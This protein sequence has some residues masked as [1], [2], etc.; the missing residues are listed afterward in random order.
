MPSDTGIRS[1]NAVATNVLDRT[2]TA[3][4]TNRITYLWTAEAWL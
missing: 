3:A 1:T 4:V 2:F